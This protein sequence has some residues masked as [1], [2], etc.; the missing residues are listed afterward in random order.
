MLECSLTR[1]FASTHRGRF[2]LECDL[3]VAPEVNIVDTALGF[4]DSVELLGAEMGPGTGC[5]SG[6]VQARAVAPVDAGLRVGRGDRRPRGDRDGVP[7][8]AALARPWCV[9]PP[10][11]GPASLGMDAIDHHMH[12]S[13]AAIA[14]GDD[15]RLVFLEAKVGEQLLRDL[16]HRRS[17]SWRET[18][19]VCIPPSDNLQIDSVWVNGTLVSSTTF[20]YVLTSC[21]SYTA[22][23]QNGSNG[24]LYTL[25]YGQNTITVHSCNLAIRCAV[26]SV[27]ISRP[28]MAVTPKGTQVASTPLQDTIQ[29]FNVHN[30]TSSSFTDTLT[31]SCSGSGV[32]SCTVTGPT[33]VPATS[34]APD[35]VHYI[36]GS[37]S[38]TGTIQLKA[39]GGGSVDSGSVAVAMAYAKSLH[40]NSTILNQD[41]QD[42]TRCLA[43]CFA[44]MVTMS[45]PA[46]VS[47]DTPRAVSLIY[48]SAHV[49]VRPILSVDVSFAADYPVKE[50]EFS[51]QYYNAV[52]AAWEKVPFFNSDGQ[53]V[54]HFSGMP[55]LDSTNVPFR[56]GGQFDAS[57][58]QTNAGGQ[59]VYPLKVTVTALYA[60]SGNYSE[61]FVDSVHHLLVINT[62]NSPVANG[63]EIAGVSQ[64]NWG[65]GSSPDQSYEVEVDGDGSARLYGPVSCP[66]NCVW[67]SPAGQ[68]VANYFQYN[69]QPYS[70]VDYPDSSKALYHANGYLWMRIGRLNDTVEYGYDS[71]S[72]VDSITD[73]YRL[74]PGSSKHT[75]WD[76]EYDSNG[77]SQIIEPG[78]DG[79]VDSGRVTNITVSPSGYLTTWQDPGGGTTKFSYDANQRLDS[80][81]DRDGHTTTYSYDLA[82]WTLTG[83]TSPPV[84]IDQNANGDTVDMSLT[85]VYNTW[86]LGGVPAH[87]TSDSSPAPPIP[88]DTILGWTITP[89]GAQTFFT[90]DRWGQAL[91]VMDPLS[92]RTTYVRDANGFPTSVTYPTGQVNSATY[93]GPF[94]TSSTPAGQNATYYTY[95]KYAQ[96]DS[97]YGVG[98]PTQKFFVSG[99]YMRG[100]IDSIHVAGGA[101]RGGS[102]LYYYPAASG[103]N[104]GSDLVMIDAMGDTT[105]YAYDATTGNRNRVADSLSGRFTSTTFD[106]Y[107]RVSTVVVSAPTGPTTVTTTYYDTLNRVDSVDD[108]VHASKTHFHY[109]SLYL[110]SITDPRGQQYTYTNNAL[111]WV[112]AQTDP[113]ARSIYTT[114]NLQ[115]LQATVRNRVGKLTSYTYDVVGRPRI[116]TRQQSAFTG[117]SGVADTV[118]YSQTG[119]IV[120]A[121]NPLSTDIIYYSAANGWADS[122]VSRFAGKKLKRFYGHDTLGRIDSLSI[123]DSAASGFDPF[124]RYYYYNPT[125]GYVD[126][127]K[128]GPKKITFAYNA[129]YQ[130]TSIT[131]PDGVVRSDTYT[132]TLATGSTTW[133]NITI[134]NS[135]ATVLS[136]GYGYDSTGRMV[137]QDINATIQNDTVLSYAYS[138]LGQLVQWQSGIWRTT[139]NTCGNRLLGYGCIP[140]QSS[141]ITTL[142]QDNAV[143]D[144]AG[145][146]D[147]IKIGSVDTVGVTVSG[148]NRISSWTGLT[149][150]SDTDGNRTSVTAGSATT[151]YIWSTDG[152]L[153]QVSN[154]TTT[155]TYYYNALGQ[156]IRR[157]EGTTVDQYYLWDSGQLLAILSGNA[158]NRIAEFAYFGTDQPIARIT[159]NNGSDTVHYY[160]QDAAG[161]V[162]TQWNGPLATVEQ[163]FMYD[164][165]GAALTLSTTTKDTTQ[166]RWKGLLYEN[167]M[168]SLYYT[169]ARWYD[170]VTRRFISPDPLGLAA[171][172]NQYAYAGVIR[173]MVVIRQAWTIATMNSYLTVVDSSS[174]L[175]RQC[176]CQSMLLRLWQTCHGG[177]QRTSTTVFLPA[178]RLRLKAP[179][180]GLGHPA[181][182]PRHLRLRILTQLVRGPLPDSWAHRSKRSHSSAHSRQALGRQDLLVHSSPEER[183]RPASVKRAGRPRSSPG[184]SIDMA[185]GRLATSSA[186]LRK[187]VALHRERL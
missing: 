183:K 90:P 37:P 14:V 91:T 158:S 69:N 13:V 53:Y 182:T 71:H 115:G 2:D 51:A 46:Y 92:N 168:T 41:D 135:S 70:E 23:Y 157:S 111:G 49:A 15:Q 181:A 74:Q 95:Q 77:I 134:P 72:R 73:P 186:K 113:T 171:G 107:G 147:T 155:R 130:P 187:S 100:H 175:R 98:Q 63:W 133:A 99:A 18:I 78:A 105:S 138:S 161:N 142:Q 119:N 17:A 179:C 52:A 102:S 110:S 123:V 101:A 32:S 150:G 126:S 156:L 55:F 165:W 163:Q 103:K 25:A 22:G 65:I 152:L 180:L 170:P 30:Y 66:S 136:R 149:F 54:V 96:P 62:R 178:E 164:P 21:G 154:G 24:T 118:S 38:T 79:A 83:V 117:D 122:T 68:S 166:L 176:Y 124:T 61:T 12:V 93:D 5:T 47:R 19:D 59:A 40:V 109:D 137:E 56:V 127:L 167:G 104:E 58:L 75:Y 125:F 88:V 26:N 8:S 120:T 128:L 80:L 162:F 159:G 9:V 11:S 144:A 89:S 153:R 34:I 131:Y 116:T 39:K 172:I 82:S 29:I 60:D 20:S 108:H 160:A 129:N 4:V 121:T 97:I 85:T 169:R 145:N 28:T 1:S 7:E 50:V 143:W 139:I 94:L 148:N 151:S 35:T 3:E 43:S 10:V 64:H 16:R 45:T 173:S 146:L 185:P 84:A 86:Q 106:G 42:Y 67:P 27:T 132:S 44:T 140:G 177:G 6:D 81:T 36:A 31:Q 141:N 33:V 174:Q 48:N 57:G 76:I 112:I 184:L 114:Y 87:P